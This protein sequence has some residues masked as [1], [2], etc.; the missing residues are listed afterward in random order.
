MERPSHITD[1]H[2]ERGSQ[3]SQIVQSD[4]VSKG[5]TFEQSVTN[6]SEFLGIERESVLLGIGI[7]NEW[8]QK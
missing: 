8:G 6:L 5:Y 1:L 2:V 3:M 7:S 4:I